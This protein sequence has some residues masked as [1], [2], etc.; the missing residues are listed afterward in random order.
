[1]SKEYKT[2][3]YWVRFHDRFE[4]TIGYIDELAD[5]SIIGSDECI[6]LN[7]LTIGTKIDFPEELEFE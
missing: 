4:W 7:R 5:C 2:G 1:M 3:F 6:N